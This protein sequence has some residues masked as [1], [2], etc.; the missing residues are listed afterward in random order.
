MRI[1]CVRLALDL[2]HLA[3]TALD[4]SPLAVPWGTIPPRI[5]ALTDELS[6]AWDAASDALAA[7]GLSHAAL[8]AEG[9]KRDLAGCELEL[10]LDRAYGEV[11]ARAFDAAA[12]NQPQPQGE[13]RR[14]HGELNRSAVRCAAGP[15][16]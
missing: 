1:L 15:G 11:M 14:R 10:R 4:L 6:A 2:D 9:D 7:A 12:G 3:A 16:G 5:R 8:A 13:E